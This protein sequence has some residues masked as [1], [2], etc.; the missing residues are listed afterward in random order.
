MEPITLVET[1]GLP[2]A[3]L[4]IA[5]LGAREVWKFFTN[6]YWPY[7][8][9]Q[10]EATIARNEREQER[11]QSRAAQMAQT[12]AAFSAEVQR[13]ADRL[14]KLEVTCDAAERALSRVLVWV[15]RLPTTDTEKPPRG[16]SGSA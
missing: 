5:A 7:H 12:L 15:D 3:A 2:G 1:V 13:L 6:T 8:L 11:E 10:R 9:Q 4:V 14:D 16:R